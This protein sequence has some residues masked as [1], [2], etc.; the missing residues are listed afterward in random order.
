M[1][2]TKRQPVRQ[3]MASCAILGQVRGDRVGTRYFYTMEQANENSD[4]P[5]FRWLK[6]GRAALSQAKRNPD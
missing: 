5:Y 4:Q 6:A 3:P 2:K 1:A